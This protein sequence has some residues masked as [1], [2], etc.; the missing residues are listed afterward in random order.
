LLP[1]H[2][3]AYLELHAAVWPAVEAAI[4]ASNIQNYTIFTVGDVLFSYFEY[5][6]SD[7]DLDMSRIA[8]DPVTK[9]WWTFTDP[10]Q[11]NWLDES[12]PSRW[13]DAR[14]IWHLE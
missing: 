7:F 8:A 2:R 9:E 5:T 4:T 13:T 10:C 11:Q 3:S 14:E 6:G 12:A 1:E